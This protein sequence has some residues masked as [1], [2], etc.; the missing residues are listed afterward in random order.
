VSF[1]THLKV[2]WKTSRWV[3][4]VC[5]HNR[6]YTLGNIG[7]SPRC[8]TAAISHIPVLPGYVQSWFVKSAAWKLGRKN[9]QSSVDRQKEIKHSTN[10]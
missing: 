8:S 2:K 10:F 9:V 5:S 6:E 4:E 1:N 7:H 3:P